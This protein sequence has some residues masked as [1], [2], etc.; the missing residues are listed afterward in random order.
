MGSTVRW[1]HGAAPAALLVAVLVPKVLGEDSPPAEAPEFNRDVRPILA[2]HC[3]SCHG[4]DAADRAA[5]LRLDVGH[6]D[7]GAYRERAGSAGIVPGSLEDSELWYRLTTE[8][9]DELMPP[10]D[11]H[12]EPLDEAERDVIRRWIEAGATFEEHWA[13]VAPRD[14]AAAR[15][16]ER[17]W[18]AGPIDDL[19]RASLDA[20]GLA[21]APRADRRTLIRRASLDLTGLPPTRDEIRAFLADERPDAYARLVDDLLARPA[22]GEHMARFWLDLVRFADTNG[23]HHDHFRDHSPYRDWVIRAFNGNLP[24]DE[25]ATAQLAG[26]LLPDAT[27]DQLTASG[28]LRLHLIIDRG[29]ML[30]EESLSR[31]VIDRVSAFGTAFM[32]MT[33]QCAVCHDHKYDPVR[34]KDFFQLY[35]F[36]NNLDGAPETGGRSG[37]DFVRG[38][39]P[40]YLRFPTEAQTAELA[41]VDEKIAAARAEQRA[42]E[43]ADGDADAERKAALEAA[44]SRARQLG[45]ERGRVENGVRAVMVMKERAEPRPAHVFV[46]GAYDQ[47]GEEVVRDTPAFLP[48]LQKANEDGPATRLDLARWVVDPKNPLTA[49]VAVNR[50]W[51]QLFGVGLVKTSE[52]F[53]TRGEWPRH[54]GLLDHLAVSFVESGW[55]VKALVREIV[56]S[57]TYRQASSAPAGAFTAD[58]ENRWLARGSRYRLDAEVIRDQILASSG[59]LNDEMFGKSVKPPQPAGVWKSVT[60]PDSYPRVFQADEGDATRRRSVYTFWKRG[61]PPPQMTILNAP[62]RESCVARRERTNTPLQA[63]LLLNEEEYLRAARHL[64]R[65]HGD[66]DDESARLDAIY[67]TITGR[68]PEAGVRAALLDALHDLTA[69]YT[70]GPEL[71]AELCAGALDHGDPGGCDLAAWT[72]VTSAIYNLDATRTRD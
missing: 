54:L 49:R 19:V 66:V 12:A 44:K 34:Q 61:L 63:L 65:S 68:L 29:T 6:G 45:R 55:D 2:A 26:D 62:N 27:V 3:F 8:F 52:D 10:P 39:Q 67:E 51:Q 22:Y 4:P 40:P 18:G 70:K 59:L 37:P 56:L 72:M 35:A 53:G 69:L 11:S 7:E 21:P 60:L 57:E 24:Y 28:F 14:R 25:F 20:E 32:G 50:V 9:E 33:L 23:V 38:V 17:P 43:S 64:A 42:L 48:P 47:L 36:F 16:G 41:A 46:R 5:S 31:N 1:R 71:A 58:P 30:P 15:T 13:F